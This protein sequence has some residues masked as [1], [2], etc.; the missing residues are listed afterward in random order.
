MLNGPLGY[1][2]RVHATPRKA[3]QH[4]LVR[5]Q[6]ALGINTLPGIVGKGTYIS[7][8]YLLTGEKEPENAIPRVKHPVIGPNSPGES[9]GPGMGRV[10]VKA[11]YSWLQGRAAGSTCDATTIPACPITPVLFPLH[12]R[13]HRSVDV[14]CELVS[15]LLG[16]RKVGLQ[17]QSTER[18]KRAGY[19]APQLLCVY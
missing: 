17:H 4:R 9:G 10:G 7:A 2:R 18:P 11:R 8:N 6:A 13:P 1:S 16:P 15:Q 19:F 14:G 3:Q 12:K 5:T